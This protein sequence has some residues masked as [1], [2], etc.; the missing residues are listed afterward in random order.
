MCINKVHA[1]VTF[2]WIMIKTCMTGRS[3]YYDKCQVLKLRTSFNM[4]ERRDQYS[5]WL[6]Q[7]IV[8]FVQYPH[9]EFTDHMFVSQC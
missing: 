9:C 8:S 2:M 6:A 5:R 7:E 1:F 4:F 3:V